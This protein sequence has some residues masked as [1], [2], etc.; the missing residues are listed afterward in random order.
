Q[1]AVRGRHRGG[2]RS[3]KS[4]DSGHTG[5]GRSDSADGVRRWADGTVYAA[6]PDRRQRRDTLLADGGFYRDA[7]GRGAD[8]QAGRRSGGRTGGLPDAAH[9]VTIKATI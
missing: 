8:S 5:G 2:G 3:R 6:Y 9:G 1:A 4:H 7:M